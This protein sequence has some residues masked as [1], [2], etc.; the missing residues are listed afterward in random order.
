V[1]ARPFYFSRIFVDPANRDRLICVGLI[2]SLSTDGGKTFKPISTNAGWDYHV[3]WWSR[4]GRRIAVGTDEGAIF[5]GDAAAHFWQP[6]D[7]P[8]SQ[9]YHAGYGS[10]APDYVVCA[11]LQDNS[12]WCGPSTANN[13]R[14]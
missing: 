2:L 3:A 13:G 11:G 7:L 14:Q 12:S 8:F 6:Y 10:T 5:S 9:T 1:G 4:D